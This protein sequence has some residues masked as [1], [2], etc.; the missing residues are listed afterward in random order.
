VKG[1]VLLVAEEFL[2]RR[3]PGERGRGRRSALHG[4]VDGGT[5][6]LMVA[7]GIVE[8]HHGQEVRGLHR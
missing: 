1:E 7:A 8:V 5:W 2:G 6:R 3:L 4:V